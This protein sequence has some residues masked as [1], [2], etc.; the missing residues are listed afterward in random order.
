MITATCTTSLYNITRFDNIIKYY[1]KLDLPMHCSLVQYPEAIN[2][3]YL[4]NELKQKV[5]K[6]V[7]N[8][9]ANLSKKLKKTDTIRLQ[10]GVIM[11][12]N[13]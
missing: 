4:P 1:N 9:I 5:N 6:E 8:T 3:Q 7:R 2:I 12:Y 11:C 10:N 13:I